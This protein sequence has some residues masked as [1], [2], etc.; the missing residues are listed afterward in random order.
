[1]RH[2]VYRIAVLVLLALGLSGCPKTTTDSYV[3]EEGIRVIAELAVVEFHISEVLK[4]EIKGRVMGS[5][6]VILL[7][8][9]VVLGSID[10][11]DIEIKIDN[12]NKTVSMSLGKVTVHDPEIGRNGITVLYDSTN[13]RY[14]N[15]GNI[16]QADRNS[17]QNQLIANIKTVAVKGGIEAKT[18]EEAQR[19]LGAFLQQLGYTVAFKG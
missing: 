3:T 8:R 2:T 10:L 7:G 13:S 19:A 18:R 17:W 9:G 16:T 12:A 11:K 1:M 6:T 4:K 5:D 15:W 14:L